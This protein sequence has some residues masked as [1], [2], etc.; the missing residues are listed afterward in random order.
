M[1]LDHVPT[2]PPALPASGKGAPTTFDKKSSSK[3]AMLPRS[4]G[5]PH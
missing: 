2:H 5:S 4:A 1:K 3:L